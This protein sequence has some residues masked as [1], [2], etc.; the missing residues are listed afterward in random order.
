[1]KGGK[2]KKKKKKP[3]AAGAAGGETNAVSSLP[4]HL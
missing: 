2:V 3:E 1:M 4:M